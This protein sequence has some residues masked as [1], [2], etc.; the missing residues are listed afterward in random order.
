M[1]IRVYIG[2]TEGPAEVLRVTPEDPKVRSVVCLDG[3][4]VALPIARNYDSFVR[5]PTGVV[6][7]Y[8]GHAAFRIDVGAPIEMGNSWQLGVFAAH[9]LFAQNRLARAGERAEG[10]I[11]LTG[12]VDRALTVNPVDHIDEKITR[13]KA[14]FGALAQENIPLTV[15]ASRDNAE[16]MSD[17]WV[18]RRGID[19]SQCRIVALDHVDALCRELS[20][21]RLSAPEFPVERPQRSPGIRARTLWIAA[22]LVVSIAVLG[23][24][25]MSSGLPGWIEL[26]RTARMGDLHDSLDRA[27]AGDCLSCGLMARAYGY[28]LEHRRP[29]ESTIAL[30]IFENRA[31]PEKPCPDVG[32]EP[33]GLMPVAA[34]SENRL[35]SSAMAGLCALVFEVTNSGEPVHLWAFAQTVP[36][37]T[38]LLADRSALS[39]RTLVAPGAQRWTVATPKLAPVRYQFVALASRDPVADPVKWMFRALFQERT[40]PYATDWL[41]VVKELNRRGVTAVSIWHEMKP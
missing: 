28:W 7:K 40:R 30:A 9:A 6:E 37:R 36:D 41:S 25:A 27:A 15:Y 22:A 16:I 5:E 14:L 33:E 1:A 2:T 17:E 24:F 39:S 13:S 32:I 8:F 29:T 34:A 35:Q 31:A 38:Y 19:P 18:V 11:W 3:K 26:H 12:E 10:A 21:P 20:L 4:T 23:L